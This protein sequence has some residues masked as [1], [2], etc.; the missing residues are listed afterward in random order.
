M[1]V[2]DILVMIR[3]LSIFQMPVQCEGNV[4][5]GNVSRKVV[6]WEAACIS[7][8]QYKL[9]QGGSCDWCA[10]V[11]TKRLCKSKHGLVR[12]A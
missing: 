1:D 10:T 7:A 2:E 11:S 3:L 9:L 8:A 6:L 4:A 5:D 12:L